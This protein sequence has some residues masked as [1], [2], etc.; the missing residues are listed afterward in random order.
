MKPKSDNP[1][2]VE[3]TDGL[4][5]IVNAFQPEPLDEDNF[6]AFYSDNTMTIR[7]GDEHL[8][9]LDDLFDDCTMPLDRNAHL[10][11]GHRGC[12]KST[13]LFGLKLRLEE[14]G[15]PVCVID[16]QSEMNLNLANCWDIMLFISEGLCYIADKHEIP[17]PDDLVYD[18]FNYILQDVETTEEFTNAV[19]IDI[20]FVLKL[21]AS[22]K[23]GLQMGDVQRTTLKTKM[24]KRGSDWKRYVNEIS[25][26][27]TD[28]MSGFQPIL[29]FED[30][31]K[32][33]PFQRALD[34]FTYDTLA[35]MPFPIVYTFPIAEIYSSK[36]ASL[37]GLYKTHILPMIQV[38]D[39]D[40]TRND[41][42]IIVIEE[43]INKR[44]DLRF[45]DTDV[46]NLLTEQTGGVLRHLFECILTACRIALRRG[47]ENIMM[48][49]AERALERL[50]SELT[51]PISI[52]DNAILAN[53]YNNIN[54]RKQLEDTSSVLDHMHGLIVLEYQN[55]ERWHDLHPLVAAFLKERGA[56]NGSNKD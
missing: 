12:G 9:P 48:S 47:S 2:R 51:R 1:K 26:L 41:A 23:G 11:S 7:M 15:H 30:L 37:K 49:D 38:S 53:I 6:D 21:I 43:I 42:G 56:I 35:K 55:G 45:F 29:I 31:D 36:F 14:A 8:S 25:I 17:L 18:M 22:I 19:N 28:A 44:A 4:R 33:Q 27:I 34:I 13:E 24:E 40:K 5:A 52:N 39:A 10:L 46:L 20:G 16:C 54:Y 3:L 32:I 50:S